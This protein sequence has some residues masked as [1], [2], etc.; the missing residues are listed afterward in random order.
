MASASGMLSLLQPGQAQAASAGGAAALHGAELAKS[1]ADG[2][3]HQWVVDATL[4][5]TLLVAVL[6]FV[7]CLVTLVQHVWLL[8]NGRTLYE[9]QQIRSG[10]RKNRPSLFDYGVAY[11]FAPH[12]RRTRCSGCAPRARG[13]MAMAS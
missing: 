1:T 4:L 5:C 10:R 6:L 7:P 2:E 12:P 8:A 13:S 9:W 11:N 3:T